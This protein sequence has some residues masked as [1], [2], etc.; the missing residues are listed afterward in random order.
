MTEKKTDFSSLSDDD[1]V[2]LGDEELALLSDKERALVDRAKALAEIKAVYDDGVLTINGRD[3]VFTT[4]PHKKRLQVFAYFTGIQNMLNVEDLSFMMTKEYSEVASTI[5]Q[6]VTFNGT[7]LSKKL[8]HWN[9]FPQDYVTFITTAL[10][11][12][13]YPFLHGKN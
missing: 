1:L 5:E 7:L 4:A 13:S 9:E 11:V 12:V 6:L 8:N 10:G 3:Y 2:A